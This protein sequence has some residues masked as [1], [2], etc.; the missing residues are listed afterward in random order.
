[1]EL[2]FRLMRYGIVGVL[3]AVIHLGV[4]YVG[5]EH[6]GLESTLASSIGFILCIV[7]NYLMHYHWTF[8]DPEGNDQ[9][10]HGQALL[11]YGVMVVCGFL[12]NALVMY[13]GVH[14]LSWHYLVT[15]LV[16][17]ISVVTWN[18][19]VSNFWVYRQ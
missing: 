17:V 8:A 15:Q 9:V 16:A 5:V 6:A 12:I 3:T 19:V 11:R 13:A 4:T 2:I 18:L 1:M 14:W 10:P 7:F